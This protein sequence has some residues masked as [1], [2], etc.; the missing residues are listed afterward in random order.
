ML[1]NGERDNWGFEFVCYVDGCWVLDFVFEL[2]FF[3]VLFGY[4]F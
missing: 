1:V 4:V 3:L 2:L